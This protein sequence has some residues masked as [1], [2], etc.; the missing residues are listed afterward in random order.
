[1]V[2]K[3]RTSE[4]KAIRARSDKAERLAT[5]QETLERTADIGTDGYDSAH[6]IRVCYNAACPDYRR[7]RRGSEQC[8][9]Q[10]KT[11]GSLT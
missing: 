10:R 8:G 9:C 11:V 7:E 5:D 6:R 3:Q 4:D 1:M 2:K